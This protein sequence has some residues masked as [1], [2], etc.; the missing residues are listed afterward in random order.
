MSKELKAI[1][2]SNSVLA[3]ELG[4]TV[5]EDALRVWFDKSASMIVNKQL[6]TRG[7]KATVED[8]GSSAMTETYSGYVVRAFLAG[9]LKGAEKVHAKELVTVTQAIS[10]DVKAGDFNKFL[11]SV[12]TWSKFKS[13]VKPKKARGSGESSSEKGSVSESMRAL[14]ELLEAEDFDG[15]I[16]EI[17]LA[18]KVLTRLGAQ[19]KISKQVNH[20]S[21]RV[22]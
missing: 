14:L 15:I 4:K 12:G 20:P 17:E 13:S 22:A 11:A 3:S 9:Q 6:S 21:V 7:W 2:F 16:L 8:S 5:D 18:E 19:V 10:R 1:D